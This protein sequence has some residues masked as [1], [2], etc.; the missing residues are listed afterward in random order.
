MTDRF[1][2]LILAIF[3]I[4]H[5]APN[6][7]AML[8]E[9]GLNYIESQNFTLTDIFKQ[10]KLKF[11]IARG[12]FLETELVTTTNYHLQTYKQVEQ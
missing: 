1:P 7:A 12:A 3:V 8:F 5:T 2:K 4:I 10:L 9:T 6:V 11:F